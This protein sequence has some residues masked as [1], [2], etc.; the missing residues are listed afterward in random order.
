M[1]VFCSIEID[2]LQ[3]SWA[4]AMEVND[5]SNRFYKLQQMLI[6]LFKF[7]KMMMLLFLCMFSF[8]IPNNKL[9][10]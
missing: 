9:Q 1:L 5:W 6:Y 8:S 4:N 7:R 2:G 3:G 10:T